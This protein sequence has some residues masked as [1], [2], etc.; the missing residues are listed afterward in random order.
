MI[1]VCPFMQVT[2][3]SANA[4]G[5]EEARDA[6]EGEGTDSETVAKDRRNASVL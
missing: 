3:F 5:G 1:E 6:A 2:V 4:V